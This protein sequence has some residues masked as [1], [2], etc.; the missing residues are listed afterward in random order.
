[1]VIFPARNAKI[2]KICVLHRAIFSSFEV[3]GRCRRILPESGT[4][5]LK[6]LPEV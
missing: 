2:Y 4:S 6:H 5:M 3:R 1:M